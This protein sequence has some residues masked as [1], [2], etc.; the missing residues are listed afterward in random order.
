ME[1][2]NAKQQLTQEEVSVKL[3]VKAGHLH[4]KESIKV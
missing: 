3:R 1:E 2:D 4:L